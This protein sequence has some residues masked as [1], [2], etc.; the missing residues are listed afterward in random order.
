MS[1]RYDSRYLN[2]GSDKSNFSLV[3]VMPICSFRNQ[4]G[5]LKGVVQKYPSNGL[6]IEYWYSFRPPYPYRSSPCKNIWFSA[7][8]KLL[9]KSMSSD[10]RLKLRLSVDFKK[11]QRRIFT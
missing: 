11:I 8:V 9:R 1:S 5:V 3:G 10:K 7:D 6:N 2:Y 4:E